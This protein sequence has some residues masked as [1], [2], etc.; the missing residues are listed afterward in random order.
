MRYKPVPPAPDSPDVVSRARD[1]L[2]ESVDPDVDCCARVMDAV[3]VDRGTAADWLVFLAAL[4]LLDE[5][6]GTY[7]QS[8]AAVERG[9]LADAF[10]ERVY[11]AR[12]LVD[13]LDDDPRTV[14]DIASRASVLRDAE[15][16]A[17]LL[18]WCQLLGLAER[19][20]GGYRVANE[21]R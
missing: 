4:G 3:G 21:R 16:V 20:D 17:R 2:P 18:A 15:R 19:A 11:G 6:D 5:R 10:V 8:A 14:E 12:E 1:S 9:A 13:V 7:A